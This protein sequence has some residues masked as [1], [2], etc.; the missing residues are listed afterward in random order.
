MGLSSSPRIFTKV[1]KPVF[2]ALR[3]QYG[4]N[5]SGYIDDSFYTKDTNETCQ[6]STLHAVDLF[7]KLGFVG[8]PTKSSLIPSQKLEFLGFLLN[9]QSMTVSLIPK[10]IAKVIT[11]C[12]KYLGNREFP[13]REIASLIGTLVGTFP[14]VDS[15]P[16]YY[17]SLVNDI[18]VV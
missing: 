10:K 12:Q 4:H 2:A 5:C 17:R 3:S 16:L 1:L 6:E 7:T 14:G 8:H 11:L 13:I 9:S 18:E 15:D